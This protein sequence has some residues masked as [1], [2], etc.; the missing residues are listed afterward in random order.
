MR[1]LYFLGTGYAVPEEG[2]ENTHLF[3]Q[4]GQRGLLV[5]CAS[6]PMPQLKKAG[7]ALD[8]ITDLVITHF[9]PDHAS[10]MPMLLMSMWLLGRRQPLHLYGLAH[11]VERAR[12]LM[13]MFDWQTW[14]NFFPTHFHVLP[15]APGYVAMAGDGFRVLTSPMKHLI[16]SVGLRVELF[17]PGR[18]IAYTSDT[19]P[20]PAAVEL[21]KRADI[22]IHE[23]AGPSIGHSSPAQAGE[24]GQ[25]AGAKSLY[26]IHTSPEQA[27][28]AGM[29]AQARNAFN[30]E[31]AMAL[32][33]LSIE[34]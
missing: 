29:L 27:R 15:E 5:D 33:G 30:G 34:L 25:Q 11:T 4:L 21:A 16:P 17:D 31:V 32:D 14:P 22:L 19:E 20:C 10:G 3:F 13:D 8:Q 23:S 7:I 9:H 24:C 18:V 6:N 1:R 26:L 12:Q 2:H 28:Y